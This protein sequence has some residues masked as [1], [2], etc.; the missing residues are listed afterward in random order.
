[1]HLGFRKFPKVVVKIRTFRHFEKELFL[2][3]ETTVGHEYDKI[4]IASICEV[5]FWSFGFPWKINQQFRGETVQ[6]DQRPTFI[7]QGI[8]GER[9]LY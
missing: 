3:N 6:L 4:Q 9:F 2:S 5:G 7:S 8:L 1:M